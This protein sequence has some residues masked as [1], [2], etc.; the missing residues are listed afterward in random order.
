[1]LYLYL[2]SHWI[3]WQLKQPVMP[4][5]QQQST[6]PT[7]EQVT[8]RLRTIKVYGT[9][10][11]KA[12][13][14]Q[15]IKPYAH[16]Y[17]RDEIKNKQ[18]CKDMQFFW[19]MFGPEYTLRK[20]VNANTSSYS[21]LTRFHSFEMCPFRIH[22]VRVALSRL[23]QDLQYLLPLLPSDFQMNKTMIELIV[24]ILNNKTIFSL[25]YQSLYA[26][27]FLP[28]NAK[29]IKIIITI[30]CNCTFLFYNFDY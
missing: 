7:N 16:H 2:I 11:S 21:T 3:L 24:Q 13:T 14:R 5:I 4:H 6:T 20:Y 8:I 30:S 29:I 23:P 27:L 22:Q 9:K 15:F 1:M 18:S 12:A 28:Q 26:S 17:F 25:D 19:V 10:S